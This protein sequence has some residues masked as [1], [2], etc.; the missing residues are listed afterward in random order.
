MK[1]LNEF[2]VVE[3]KQEELM[4]VE[5]GTIRWIFGAVG[6]IW[7]GMQFGFD[8]DDIDARA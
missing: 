1:N 8:I 3:L 2:G 4:K 5:G 7:E 6:T